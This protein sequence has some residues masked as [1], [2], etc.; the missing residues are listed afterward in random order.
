M[1]NYKDINFNKILPELLKIKEFLEENG[2]GIATIWFDNTL[3]CKLN[4]A[5]N[6]VIFLDPKFKWYSE[7]CDG[8]KYETTYLFT[9]D[10]NHRMEL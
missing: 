4:N 2:C 8:S 5:E 10:H 7:N 1:N 6:V 9:F 3:D